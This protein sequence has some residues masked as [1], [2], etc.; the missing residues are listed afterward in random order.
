MNTTLA[1][2]QA[3]VEQ[4]P[5]NELARFSLGKALFEA[6]QWAQAQ[7]HL[8]TATR[9][10]PDWMAAFILRGKCALALGDFA[11]ARTVLEQARA[12]AIRQRHQGP[13]EETERL[14]AQVRSSSGSP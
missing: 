1:R 14:L 2:L 13:L 8:A 6:G 11:G 9:L 10:Q 3:R 5:D 12:L 4:D 7:E